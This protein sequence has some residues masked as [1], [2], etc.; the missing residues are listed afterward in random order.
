MPSDYNAYDFFLNTAPVIYFD[1]DTDGLVGTATCG[2]NLATCWT[3]D[4]EI[5][6]QY[7]T[8]TDYRGVYQFLVGIGFSN[9][10]VE[11]ILVPTPAV[12]RE[13]DPSSSVDMM[14]YVP[15]GASDVLAHWPIEFRRPSVLRMFGHAW[16]WAG[17]LNYTK[18][19]PQYQGD[20]TPQN[21]FTYYFTNELGG[22]VYATGFNQEG[23][24]VTAAGLT[25]LSTGATTGVTD[26]GN[27]FAGVDIPTYYPALTV[28]NLNV[29]TSLEFSSGCNISGSP[30]FAADWYSNFRPSTVSE[31]GI[32]RLATNQE[33]QKLLSNNTAI[34]PLSLSYAI[35]SAIKS[36]VNLRMSLSVNSAIPDVDQADSSDIYIHP[37][38]GNEIALYNTSEQSWQIVSFSGVL[39]RSLA[40]AS[41]PSTLYDVYLYNANAANPLLAPNIQVE[42]VA[43]SN[44]QTPPSRA[45]QNGILCKLGDPAR[46]FVAVMRT[47]T[48]GASRVSLGGAIYGTSSADYPRLYLANVYNLYDARATYFF[49]NSWNVP[50]S[51]IWQLVPSSV[52]P[53]APRIS[54]VQTGKSLVT[55]FLDIYNNP[56][57]AQPGVTSPVSLAY[58][59]PGLNLDIVNGPIE[60]VY[61]AFYGETQGDNQ[62]TGSQWARALTPGLHDV[63]YLYKQGSASIINEHLN[64]GMIAIVK[65]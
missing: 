32:I 65:I 54:F 38:N 17:F 42:F 11:D 36:V 16:E 6:G 4:S 37:Y 39:A 29:A 13:L 21:Q 15:N 50:A 49:G 63:Y 31:P 53:V 44:S 45:T 43:W 22:R 10:E 40:P 48:A 52:Y 41:S 7:R 26:I 61:D 59:A 34:S 56:G 23:Y 51:F 60:P 46:R 8:A 47:T 57:E 12:N 2:Y 18:A 55:C 28:D 35:G 20:L 9:E 58:V 27:P 30:T 33:A 25:D 19:L 14:G 64:H 1:N 62:T 24:F 5:K 3:S